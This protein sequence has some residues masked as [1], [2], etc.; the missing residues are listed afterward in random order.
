MNYLGLLFKLSH[1]GLVFYNMEY[2]DKK[3]KTLKEVKI[4]FITVN[5]NSHALF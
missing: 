2:Q 5:Y 1:I 4:A 3:K